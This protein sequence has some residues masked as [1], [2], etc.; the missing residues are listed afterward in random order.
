MTP[1][2]VKSFTHP[3]E[4]PEIMHKLA[5]VTFVQS[6]QAPALA[7]VVPLL[8]KGL[9]ERKTATRRQSAVIVDNMSKLVDDPIDAEPF[10]PLLMPGT[11]TILFS[12]ERAML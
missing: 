5:G 2:I 9:K 3:D 8:I 11:Y 6:V 10:L 4:V 1:F 7:M 12:S